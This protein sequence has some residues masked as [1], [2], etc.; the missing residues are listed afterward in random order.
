MHVCDADYGQI[1]VP[2]VVAVVPYVIVQVFVVLLCVAVAPQLV[3]EAAVMLT[4]TLVDALNCAAVS[5]V[6]YVW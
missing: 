3:P 1:G 5:V 6:V 4:F 2:S